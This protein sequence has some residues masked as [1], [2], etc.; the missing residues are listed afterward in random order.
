MALYG[1]FG[2]AAWIEYHIDL[3]CFKVISARFYKNR[4]I[5]GNPIHYVSGHSL[6]ENTGIWVGQGAGITYEENEKQIG[7]FDE[8][9]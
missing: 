8:E 3:L 9:K 1:K 2:R 6:E 7:D 5:N 4:C